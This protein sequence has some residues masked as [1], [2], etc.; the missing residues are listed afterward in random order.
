MRR[1]VLSA[2]ALWLAA[3]GGGG[4]DPTPPVNNPSITVSA[5][6]ASVTA[7][8]GTSATVPIIVTR[9]GGAAGDV[10]L[11]AEGLPANVT[12][13]FAPSPIP[14][15]S[16][17]STMTLVVGAGATAATTTITVRATLAGAAAQT[18]TVQLSVAAAGTPAYTITAAPAAL[19]VIAGAAGTTDLSIAKTGGFAG[20][21][22]L[23]LEGAPAGVTGAFA[24]NPATGATS[25]LTLT[26]TSAAAAGTYALTVR[27]AASG[28][29]DRTIPVSLV[30][31][32]AG[33]FA[34]SATAASAVQGATGNSTVTITRAGGFAGAVAL[35]TGTLPANVTASFNPASA[36]GATSTLTFTAG[37]TAAP[38]TYTVA[39]NGTGTGVANQTTNVTLTVTASGGGGG[40]SFAWQFC[41]AARVPAWFAFRDGTTGA[42]TRVTGGAN[43]TFS[44]TMNQSV[45]SVAYTLVT[46]GS[47]TVEVYLNTRAELQGQ[48]TA[49]CTSN[50]LA[51]K[52]LNGSVTGL[53]ALDAATISH[54]GAT[55]TANFA[56]STFTLTNVDAGPQDLLAYRSA[57][58]GSTVS[59]IFLQRGLNVAN[60]GTLPVV[61]FNGANSFA[62][63]SAVVTIANG[64]GDT[65]FMIPSFVTANGAS[66]SLFSDFT[67]TGA[68]RT[69]FGVPTANLIAGDLHAAFVVANAANNIDTRAVFS[70]FRTVAARTITLGATLNAATLTSTGAGGLARPRARGTIQAEYGDAFGASFSQS[71]SAKNITISASRGYFGAATEYELETPDFAGIAGFNPAWGL[72]AGAST[73]S[74]ITGFGGIAGVINQPADGTAWRFAS[75]TTTFTP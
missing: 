7:T 71:S 19:T 56:A 69:Y 22:T 74:S 2:S 11:A 35:A 57:L 10:S 14:A 32:S 41:D 33:S 29:T 40:G 24:P 72:V 6:T 21:V 16:T 48:S 4:S 18:A 53:A 49:E 3:C 52:T 50:P 67:A 12:A 60:G 5:G 38:G 26:T 17:T 13:T 58:G 25:T 39:V 46:G 54:G 63:A 55:T 43:N 20:S 62:P 27:G 47:S 8:Q 68:A 9:S 37:A 28:L 36:T 34:L 45:G 65:F 61:D 23:A 59:R 75:R 73:S 70:Y 31:S 30:V 51:G 1:L 66:F 44:F 15:A 42:W 64:G